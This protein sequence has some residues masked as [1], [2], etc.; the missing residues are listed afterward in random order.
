MCQ[1][2]C[3]LKSYN[4]TTRKAKCD[5]SITD[6][7]TEL[8]DLNIENLFTKK[9]IE[10]SF[11]NTLSNS[12]F[13]VLKCYKLLFSSP[14]A[15]NIGEIFMTVIFAMLL[16]LTIIF[17][18]MGPKKISNYI[19]F[20]VKYDFT[21]NIINKKNQKKNDIK[22]CK[23]PIKI[24]KL[25]KNEPPKKIKNKIQKKNSILKKN[26]KIKNKFL[27][28]LNTKPDN[29]YH[30]NIFL[31][32]NVV[33]SKKNDKTNKISK[34]NIKK[35]KI[36]FKK[37]KGESEKLNNYQRK[38]LKSNLY[39]SIDYSSNEMFKDRKKIINQIDKKDLRYKLLNDQELNSL[40][41]E[42][43]LELD[44]RTYFQY[45]WSLLKKKQ[46]LLFTFIPTNDYNL[47]TIKISLFLVSFSLYFTINGF[48][49]S[50]ETMH[51]VYVDNGKFDF[52]YQI[53]QI[54]Y[55]TI[56]STIINMI[57]KILSLSEKNILEIKEIKDHKIRVKKSKEIHMCITIKFIIFFIFS[58]IIM[59]FFWYFISCFCV[60]YKN[61]Q[62]ILIKDTLLSFCLSMVYPFGINLLPGIFR[63]PAL[64]SKNKDKQCLYKLSGIIALI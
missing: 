1:I 6:E 2:G 19:N 3:E 13:Q 57:L 42:L 14:F 60:V 50:D 59:V 33:K 40:E 28:S 7:S 32:V 51:K 38:S 64:K 41:Y 9:Q 20:V 31:N 45:Y 54:L 26:K 47:M 24:N 61:T 37:K 34:I 17:W 56:V 25:K 23:S 5:C 46:L 4:Q 44:K 12:N 62:I 10:E 29:I 18:F 49:F 58:F 63:I 11:Y 35:E 36:N 43:A 27:N 8:T 21:K 55:S 30:N 48:F 52:I 53:P 15:K 39:K 16:I 22:K